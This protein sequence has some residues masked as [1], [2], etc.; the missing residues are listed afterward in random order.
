MKK[1][2]G[3]SLLEIVL[4]ITLLAVISP[5]LFGIFFSNANLSQNLGAQV[6]MKE[7]AN[8]V[9]SFVK[10]ANY[11]SIYDLIKNQEIIGIEEVEE[12]GIV[13]RKFT[14]YESIKDK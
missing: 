1:C 5:V 13:T 4:S 3:V 10:L 11:D 6:T 7:T 8:D 9:K 2:A 12:D 14:K